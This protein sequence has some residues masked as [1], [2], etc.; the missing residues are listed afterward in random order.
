MPKR[1]SRT[2]RA[3]RGRNAFL[4]RAS[5]LLLRNI[6]IGDRAFVNLRRHADR[7]AQRRMRMDRESDIGGLGAHLDRERYF[8]NEI[9]RVRRDD[10]AADDA[11]RRFVENEL[12]EAFGA[13]DADRASRCDMRE[14]AD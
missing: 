10:A 2:A 4:S 12:R 3:K 11:M 14:L 5:S 6:E 13:A 1:R 9:S 7:F 8:R